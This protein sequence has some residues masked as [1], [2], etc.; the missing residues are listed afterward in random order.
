MSDLNMKPYW[1]A[2]RILC[3]QYGLTPEQAREAYETEYHR[4]SSGYYVR[5]LD[6]MRR[7]M[8]DLKATFGL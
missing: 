2:I 7:D 5:E 3:N 6:E 1:E 8:E 4:R